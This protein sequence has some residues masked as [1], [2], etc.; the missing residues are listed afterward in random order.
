MP[1]GAAL[2]AGAQ[3]YVLDLYPFQPSGRSAAA[4]GGTAKPKAAHAVAKPIAVHVFLVPDGTRTWLGLG[5]G[6]ALTAAKLA[7]AMGSAG[8][9][10]ASRTD[11][12]PLK[13]SSFGAAGFLT[14]RGFSEGAWQNSPMNRGKAL[15][16]VA[17]L[18]AAGASPIVFSATA[19]SDD[20]LPQVAVKVDLPRG[21]LED[22]AAAIQSHAF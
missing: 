19:G 14:V 5:G 10:L 18:P 11:L 2:P 15:D 4:S 22:I 7:L 1:K 17:K 6:D 12:A 20:K 13:T 3:H 16:E 8:D 21:A 9:K